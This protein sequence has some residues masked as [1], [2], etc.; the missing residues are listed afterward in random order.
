MTW[1]L[2]PM[3]WWPFF[4]VDADDTLKRVMYA[5]GTILTHKERDFTGGA[6]INGSIKEVNLSAQE[7]RVAAK[8]K[9]GREDMTNRIAFIENEGRHQI[10]QLDGAGQNGEVVTVRLKE[11]MVYGQ[12][13]LTRIDAQSVETNKLEG[14]PEAYVGLYLVDAGLNEFYRITKV[15]QGADQAS[16]TL[17]LAKP[18][19]EHH[20]LQAHSLVTLS[21]VGP[22]DNF[23]MPITFSWKP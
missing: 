22:D 3:H 10:H 15:E 11:P 4:T 5:D 8:R 21:C 17:Q 23:R 12:L 14:A 2:L 20:S 16:W 1:A 13:F 9:M 18:L 7:I 19:N 6:S